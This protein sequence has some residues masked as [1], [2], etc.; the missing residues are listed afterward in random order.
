MSEYD[1][2]FA[3]AEALKVE[4]LAEIGERSKPLFL[5]IK[6]GEEVDRLD[7][8]NALEFERILRQHASLKPG[9]D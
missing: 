1:L 2:K 6:S 7:G 3:Q 9:T 4:S 5:F 8:A